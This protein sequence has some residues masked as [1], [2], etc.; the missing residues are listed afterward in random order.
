MPKTSPPLQFKDLISCLALTA[1]LSG[2]TTFNPYQDQDSWDM[3]ADFLEFPRQNTIVG[4]NTAPGAWRT[5]TALPDLSGT[6][7][8]KEVQGEACQTGVAIPLGDGPGVGYSTYSG[9]T[10]QPGWPTFIGGEGGYTEALQVIYKEN[11]NI[12]ALT[13]VKIDTRSFGILT[14]RKKCVRISAKAF[15]SPPP[16]HNKSLL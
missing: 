5:P 3:S 15:V 11:E 10:A 12:A 14:F 13:D 8:I 1:V 4:I 16:A 9:F 7:E 6:H 2:C